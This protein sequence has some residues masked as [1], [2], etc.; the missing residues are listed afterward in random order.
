MSDSRR[1]RLMDIQKREQLK[2]MLINKFK[3]KYGDKPALGKYIDNE[4]ARFLKN[5]RLTEDTLRNLDSKINKEAGNRERKQEILDDRKSNASQGSR[6]SARPASCAGSQRV[7]PAADAQSVRSV[8]SSQRS[9]RSATRRAADQM[10]V[11]SSMAPPLTEVYSE[12]AEEDQWTAIQKFN[13][14]LHYEEQKQALM[15]EQERRRL[16]REELDKQVQEKQR[17]K[18]MLKEEQQMYDVL[19][20]EHVKLLAQREIEKQ[21]L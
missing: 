4:V 10:S 12:I 21:Q 11:A 14:L 9:V 3:L 15:R 5:D 18:E 20:E 6:R 16:I 19:Q 2:G 7:R 8:R 17:R 1:E 13:Q